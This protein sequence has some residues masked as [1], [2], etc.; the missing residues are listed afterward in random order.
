MKRLLLIVLTCLATGSFGCSKKSTPSASTGSPP[1]ESGSA[2][3]NTS[4]REL[5]SNEK[6]IGLWKGTE[7]STGQRAS[8]PP[9]RIQLEFQKGEKLIMAIEGIGQP[10]STYEI[11]GNKLA[12]NRT[13]PGGMKQSIVW[14][15]VKL[16]DTEFEYKTLY[17][18]VGKLTKDGSP[19]SQLLTQKSDKDFI[20]FFPPK[21]I[22]ATPQEVFDA[23][24]LASLKGDHDTY[25]RCLSPRVQYEMAGRMALSGL[26]LSINQ[27]RR[28]AKEAEFWK[29]HDQP[30]YDAM[31]KHGLT[32]E[33]LKATRYGNTEDRVE[34]VKRSLLSHVK[35]VGA[36]LV[37]C[38]NAQDKVEGADYR[39]RLEDRPRLGEVKIEGDKAKGELVYKRMDKEQKVPIEF[40]KVRAGWR[41]VPLPDG[42]K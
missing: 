38:Q 7:V 40:L 14:S 31:A 17:D 41:L 19:S 2:T 23:S 3:Q 42:G 28:T 13:G 22:Y 29:K 36:F 27:A 15:I 32:E 10:P 9:S 18:R 5:F 16:T 11:D 37:D 20:D 8:A 25:I 26:D 33:V 35:N 4:N 6:L 21:V 1:A 12:I 34:R 24:L 30:K 39:L